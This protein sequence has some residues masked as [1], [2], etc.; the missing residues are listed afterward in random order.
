MCATILHMKQAKKYPA[1]QISEAVFRGRNALYNFE[2][3]PMNVQFNEVP[4]VYIISKR[5]LDRNGRGHHFLVCIGQTESLVEDIKKHKRGGCV[6]QLQANTVSVILEDDPQKRLEVEN[7]LKSAHTIPCHHDGANDEFAFKPIVKPAPKVKLEVRKKFVAPKAEASSIPVKKP[8]QKQA[9]AKA[10][11]LPAEKIK[12]ASAKNKAKTD[13]PE[14]KRTPQKQTIETKPKTVKTVTP[15]KETGKKKPETKTQ[16]AKV[17]AKAQ[18]AEI[19]KAEKAS[20]K[21]SKIKVNRKIEASKPKKAGSVKTKIEENQPS[22]KGAK[23]QSPKTVSTLKKFTGSQ[24]QSNAKGKPESAKP[25]S[26]APKIDRAKATKAKLTKAKAIETPQKVKKD[27]EKITTAKL[28]KTFKSMK[29]PDVK[30]APGKAKVEPKISKPKTGAKAKFVEPKKIK[31]AKNAK[32]TKPEKFTK[33][34][35]AKIVK[36]EK[37]K[38]TKSS[39]TAKPEKAAPLK[40]SARAKAKTEASKSTAANRPKI[41]ANTKTEISIKPSVKGKENSLKTSSRKRLAF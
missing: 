27:S 3:Y 11:V 31:Q 19:S 7:D 26:G 4:A 17:S 23:K 37:A 32:I 9:E 15:K 36:P 39:E 20:P 12:K 29:T 2:V 1:P 10:E 18:K 30:K 22:I 24:D 33:T 13:L 8:A 16:K 14:L 6:K 25:K 35:T 28:P 5:K 41:K 21:A 38:Q 34:K 40:S